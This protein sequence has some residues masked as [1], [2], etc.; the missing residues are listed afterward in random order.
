MK[1]IINDYLG[2]GFTPA[3]WVKYGIIIPFVYALII[4]IL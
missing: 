3:E 1:E 4:A 2:E